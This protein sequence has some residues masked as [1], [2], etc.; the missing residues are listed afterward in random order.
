MSSTCPQPRKSFDETPLQYRCR[1]AGLFAAIKG[2]RCGPECRTLI[3]KGGRYSAGTGTADG[4]RPDLDRQA[5]E[6]LVTS[7]ASHRTPTRTLPGSRR[8]HAEAAHE[9]RTKTR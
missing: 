1:P 7:P 3:T 2:R 6:A 5:S 4:L 8:H 9:K